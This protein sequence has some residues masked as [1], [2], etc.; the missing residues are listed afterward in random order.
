MQWP[1]YFVFPPDRVEVFYGSRAV[2]YTWPLPS[3]SCD[4]SPWVQVELAD[5]RRLQTKLLVTKLFISVAQAPSLAQV[6]STGF[7]SDSV[8]AAPPT[9]RAQVRWV[10]NSVRGAKG[11]THWVAFSVPD[12]RKLCW[13]AEEQ[14]GPPLLVWGNLRFLLLYKQKYMCMLM[15]VCRQECWLSQELMKR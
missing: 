9:W 6:L 3:H 7:G 14:K 1:W 4:T 12:A 5:G 11:Q 15:A 8:C 2:G 13:T 10:A